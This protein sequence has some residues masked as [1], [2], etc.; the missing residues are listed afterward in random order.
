MLFAGCVEFNVF[1]T[2]VE[3]AGVV[4]DELTSTIV[5][6]LG[7]FVGEDPFDVLR[8]GF[9]Q[10]RFTDLSLVIQLRAGVGRSV[11]QAMMYWACTHQT[12]LDELVGG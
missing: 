5:V 10:D 1:S 8:S 4:V 6:D 11:T 3:S 2:E 7:L 12:T 9:G